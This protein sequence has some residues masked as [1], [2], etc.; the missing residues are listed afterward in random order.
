MKVCMDYHIG[1]K[2]S[3]YIQVTPGKD[4]TFL[5]RPNEPNQPELV[6]FVKKIIFCFL[7]FRHCECLPPKFPDNCKGDLTCTHSKQCGKHGACVKFGPKF[8][9]KGYG[10][11]AKKYAFQVFYIN[12]E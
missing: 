9:K 10:A 2:T 7:F 6:E 5:V 12:T 3:K 1:K 8:G 11:K 4:W